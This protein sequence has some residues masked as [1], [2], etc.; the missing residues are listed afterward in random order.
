MRAGQLYNVISIERYTTVENAY[1]EL[2]KTWTNLHTLRANVKQ[3]TSKEKYSSNEKYSLSTHSIAIRYIADLKETD[4]VLYRD[5]YY[6]ID[7]IFNV[8]ERNRDLIILTK[9]YGNE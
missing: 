7:G 3:L 4:R 1:G 9:E 8:E 5:N 2:T 6:D